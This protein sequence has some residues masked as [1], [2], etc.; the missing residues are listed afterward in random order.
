MFISQMVERY[1]NLFFAE[2]LFVSLL[3]LYLDKL[4]S[5]MVIA[6]LA[7]ACDSSNITQ[8]SC[9]SLSYT[10]GRLS[11]FVFTDWLI[12]TS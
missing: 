3:F 5:C 1:L 6:E 4:M 11:A 10:Y 8:H 9:A 7:C 12:I 2:V